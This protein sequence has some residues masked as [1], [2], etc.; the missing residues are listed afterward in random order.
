MSNQKINLRIADLRKSKRITQEELAN[1][2]G[3]TYQTISK[4]ENGVTMPDISVLPILADYFEVS[5]DELLG[6]KPLKG[7][8]YISDQTDSEDFRDKHLEYL[9]RT[10]NDSWN[11]D[12]LKFLITDIWKIAEPVKVL[13]CG[14]GFG[15]MAPLIMPLLPKGSE[16]IGVDFS[17]KLVED[18]AKLLKR[19]NINGCVKKQDFLSMQVNEEYDIVI[20]QSVLRHLGKSEP[21]IRKMLEATKPN[22]LIVC[23]DANRE[24]EC[25]G[26][27]IDGVSYEKL[28]D[29][30]GAI[31]H[32]NAEIDNNDRDYA[33]A[34]RTAHIMRKLGLKDVQIRMNDKVSFVCPEQEDYDR[35]I[36]DYII[37]TSSWYS[38]SNQAIKQLLVHGMTRKEAENYVNRGKLIHDYLEENRGNVCYTRFKGKM[39]TYGRK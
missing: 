24:F 23:I 8:Y 31:K 4:W 2:I 30:T 37:E 38:D 11:I 12:Y 32:W 16:Y 1:I 28:C 33:A 7:E 35:K 13:D 29:H 34:M 25:D 6:L 18:G 3:T 9:H 39:I 15:Y 19:H 21:F 20:C 10:R 17:E 22:G 14:C 26:T 27:Y 36:D 5:V